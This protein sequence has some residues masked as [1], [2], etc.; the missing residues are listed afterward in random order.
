[1]S[2]DWTDY[3]RLAEELRTR[4]DEASLRS[5]ISRAYYSVFHEA[6]DFLTAEGI[7]LSKAD[8]SHKAVWNQ[9]E[10]LGGRS[11][12]A[13]GLNGKRLND[14]RTRA[15]YDNPLDR[16]EHLVEETF[17]VA[18]DVRYYLEQCKSSR[19]SPLS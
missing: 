11:C 15:D 2:F 13:V 16:I 17:K 18:Q 8:S 9:Y 4:H 12:R 7:H 5:A 10:N 6:R 3:A 19:R 14:N 1:M